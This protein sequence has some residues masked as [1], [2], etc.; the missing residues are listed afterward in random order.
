MSVVE[1]VVVPSTITVAPINGS[2]CSSV[3]VPTIFW[4]KPNAGIARTNIIATSKRRTMLIE[5][6]F[7]FNSIE[8]K[9]LKLMI[10]MNCVLQN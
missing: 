5:L 3:T 10:E 7:E 6:D 8:Q 2:P 4:A 1:P 9:C